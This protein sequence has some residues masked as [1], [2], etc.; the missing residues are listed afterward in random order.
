M[1]LESMQTFAK[2]LV[3]GCWLLVVGC[4]LLVV[5]S[6]DMIAS[7]VCGDAAGTDSGTAE[8]WVVVVA[9][10]SLGTMLTVSFGAG[11]VVWHK[12]GASQP[13]ALSLSL[14]LAWLSLVPLVS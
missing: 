4:W 13:L 14:V 9:N 3:V 6:L 10:V 2:L 8:A 12:Y 1:S 7:L 5:G 11:V